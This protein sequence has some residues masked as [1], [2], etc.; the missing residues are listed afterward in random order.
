METS[1]HC[2]VLFAVLSTIMQRTCWLSLAADSPAQQWI[3]VA[4]RNCF[5]RIS[6]NSTVE[7]PPACRYNLICNPPPPIFL[8][9][10]KQSATTCTWEWRR[11]ACIYISTDTHL[12]T[13]TTRQSMHE[14]RLKTV[15]SAVCIR[16]W[17]SLE[18]HPKVKC[19]PVYT[20]H[21][22]NQ[23]EKSNGSPNGR[24]I[25]LRSRSLYR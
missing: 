1:R 9:G 18:K 22:I 6:R 10:L 13:Q 3:Q 11:V 20:P 2:D 19:Y 15:C 7:V 16:L 4:S 21:I 14:T 8:A 23:E 24:Y 5:L 12:P 17:H 25:A